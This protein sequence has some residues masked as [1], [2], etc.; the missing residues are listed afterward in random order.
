MPV[1]LLFFSRPEPQ[2]ASQVVE[3]VWH[4]GSCQHTGGHARTFSLT[5]CL[6][7]LPMHVAASPCWMV[8]IR[9]AHRRG[10]GVGGGGAW[11]KDNRRGHGWSRKLGCLEKRHSGVLEAA[12]WLDQILILL[13]WQNGIMGQ[14]TRIVGGHVFVCTCLTCASCCDWFVFTDIHVS[15]KGTSQCQ[16]SILNSFFVGSIFCILSDNSISCFPVALKHASRVSTCL[17]NSLDWFNWLSCYMND[18]G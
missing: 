9:L 3:M 15:P 2:T 11:S 10:V 8:F 17:M 6:A 1:R 14:K 13:L 12:G 4:N 5:A 18:V 7:L 16:G